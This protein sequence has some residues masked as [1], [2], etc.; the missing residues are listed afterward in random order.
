MVFDKRAIWKAK[1]YPLD[2]N[3]ESIT[4]MRIIWGDLLE[5]LKKLRQKA[6][7]SPISGTLFYF[8]Y[9]NKDGNWVKVEL[10]DG[11]F[12]EFDNL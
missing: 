11:T 7:N 3:K 1:L 8:K 12:P 10:E 6:E 4:I 9:S 5:T 2:K